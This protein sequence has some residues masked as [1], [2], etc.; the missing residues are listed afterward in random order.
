MAEPLTSDVRV[1]TRGA[2]QRLAEELI[3]KGIDNRSA[4]AICRAELGGRTTH[5][6]IAWYRTHMRKKFGEPPCEIFQAGDQ[7]CFNPESIEA[8]WRRLVA[9]IQHGAKGIRERFGL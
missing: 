7:H 5:K 6:C 2:V 8:S 4:A 3:R 1:A 9:Y